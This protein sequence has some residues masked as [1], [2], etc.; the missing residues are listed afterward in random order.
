MIDISKFKIGDTIYVVDEQNNAFRKNK[1]VKTDHNGVEWFRYDRP[2]YEYTIKEVIYCGKVIHVISGEVDK[3]VNIYD[4]EYH[5]KY[6]D[7]TIF[8]EYEDVI[9]QLSDWYA[10]KKEAADYIVEESARQNA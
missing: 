9:P 2:H 8:Y 7:G 5:F 3:E 6:P 1:I 4:T 10:T